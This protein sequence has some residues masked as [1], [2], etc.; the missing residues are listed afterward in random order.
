MTLTPKEPKLHTF[1]IIDKLSAVWGD[2]SVR[3]IVKWCMGGG[4]PQGVS[5][6]AV[7]LGDGT[8]TLTANLT[9]CRRPCTSALLFPSGPSFS[10]IHWTMSRIECGKVSMIR[11]SVAV[12]LV[13]HGG[14]TT[15]IG[16]TCQMRKSADLDDM[17]TNFE[18]LKLYL[19][20]L[21]ASY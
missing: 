18:S 5:A 4:S 16:V 17:W 19:A 15:P 3:E 10:R 14:R 20:S 13:F 21:A 8:G 6:Q 12:T 9:S 1:E 11:S 2:L 7:M